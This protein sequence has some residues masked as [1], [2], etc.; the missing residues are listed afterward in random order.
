[1]PSDVS[2]AV[3]AATLR[4]H[5][6]QT[7]L[8]IWRGP[9]FNAALQLPFEAVSADDHQ[10]LPVTRYRA[11]ACARQLFVFSQAGGAAH[12]HRLFEALTR[13][14][15]DT[16]QGGWFYSVDAN[17]APLD[18]TKDLYTHAFI[19]FACAEY[20][21]AF[22][23]RDALAT[24]N[25]TAALIE[26]RFAVPVSNGLLHAALDAGFDTVRGGL[27]QN[28]LMHL[29]EAYLAAS[30][31]TGDT[32]FADALARLALAVAGA[33]V[34]APTGCIAELPIGA[35]DNRL[36]PGHQFEWFYLVKRA[37][38]AI[39]A[40]GLDA[41]LERA[42]DFAQELGVDR[43]TGGVC[44]ALDERGAVKDATQ[45][46]WAQTE[47]LRALATR[48]D[49]ASLQALPQQ[50]ERFRTRFLH[51]R[52]WYEC[53]TPEGAVARADMPSTTPY[54]LATAYASLPSN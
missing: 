19:V 30:E 16:R 44:A 29:T 4:E 53:K 35:A 41:A 17:G 31:A 33:F 34:H 12:A 22:G 21:A 38:A 36:E 54:H 25:E 8:P 27:L 32:A 26:A 51:A 15:A 1:M 10:P 6:T 50:I 48:G 42:F 18:T 40:S 45:R 24:L 13:Y 52:G 37:G 23:N 3:Q 46:I 43:T 49:G 20:F 39:A 47:Y 11:M 2:T 5:F 7:I 9:G 28:P 14:F